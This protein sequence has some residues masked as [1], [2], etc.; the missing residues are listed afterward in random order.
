MSRERTDVFEN[1][2][3][4]LDGEHSTLRETIAEVLEYGD[5]F[6]DLVVDLATDESV[7]HSSS[8]WREVYQYRIIA[9]LRCNLQKLST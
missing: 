2:E 4:Q 1:C 3:L 9:M 7:P 6:S 5:E 8:P